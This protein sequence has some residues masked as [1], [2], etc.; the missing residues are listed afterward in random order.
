[1]S[2]NASSDRLRRIGLIVALAVGTL[3]ADGIAVAFLWAT[4]VDFATLDRVLPDGSGFQ[5][6][7]LTA[8]YKWLLGALLL[9]NIG[10]FLVLRLKQRRW[11]AWGFALGAVLPMCYL[12]FIL[13]SA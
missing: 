8:G 13:V 1:M 2:T 12:L 3:L 7:P 6:K 4:G 5:I 11:P 10:L 9:A